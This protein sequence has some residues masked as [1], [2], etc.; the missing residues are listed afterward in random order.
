M[1]KNTPKSQADNNQNLEKSISQ[2]SWFLFYCH[3]KA[4]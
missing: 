3:D 2:L 1:F 4:P